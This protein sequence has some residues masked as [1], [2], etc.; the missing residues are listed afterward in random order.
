MVESTGVSDDEVEESADSTPEFSE[1]VDRFGNALTETAFT[2]GEFGTIYRAFGFNDDNG[3]L[4]GN[5]AGNN[6]V[7]E[8]D[9]RGNDTT[10][11][12]NSLTSRNEE[13]VDRLGNKTAYEYDV[14]GRTTKVTSKKGDGTELANVSYAYDS[15]DNMTEIARG[16]GMKYALTYNAFTI[17][18]LSAWT[19][20]PIS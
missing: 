8:T 19:A 11:T 2:D 16:D 12:V 3:Q 13:V 14:S 9:A 5:D 7:R 20:K 15:F 1:A 6:L 10:Y 4:A 18:R 17:W